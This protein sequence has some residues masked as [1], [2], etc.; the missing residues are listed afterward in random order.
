ML[1]LEHKTYIIILLSISILSLAININ[2]NF[3]RVLFNSN[4]FNVVFLLL[5]VGLTMYNIN[6][7]FVWILIYLIIRQRIRGGLLQDLL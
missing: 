6:I 3:I 5:L 1:T 4:I 7:G 2:Y